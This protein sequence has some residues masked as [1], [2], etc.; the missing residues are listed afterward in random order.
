MKSCDWDSIK[1]DH[2]TILESE[3]LMMKKVL[4]EVIGHYGNRRNAEICLAAAFLFLLVKIPV[5]V[6]T[7]HDDSSWILVL[8]HAHQMGW[9]FG[10]DVILTFGPL[11][12]LQTSWFVD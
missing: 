9:Q 6:F 12:F 4:R 10:K 11:G 5:E 8:A 3:K 1:S 2:C 7:T